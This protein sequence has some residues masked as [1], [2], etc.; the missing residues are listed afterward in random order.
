FIIDMWLCDDMTLYCYDL[1]K[2]SNDEDSDDDEQKMQ[3]PFISF[4]MFSSFLLFML[5]LE[6]MTFIFDGIV[7]DKCYWISWLVSS[8]GSARLKDIELL[9]VSKY[10]YIDKDLT[11][12][13]VVKKKV[14]SVFFKLFYLFTCCSLISCLMSLH[15]LNF[16][17]LYFIFFLAKKKRQNSTN[18]MKMQELSLYMLK[19]TKIQAESYMQCNQNH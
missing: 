19:I 1:C 13:E 16:K 10:I 11:D 4:F 3:K 7:K 8:C 15:K 5:I 14:L 6:E 18:L 2:I 17:L 12:N 9:L